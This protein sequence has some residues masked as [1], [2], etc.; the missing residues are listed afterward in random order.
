MQSSSIYNAVEKK[1]QPKF[2][3][4]LEKVSN[5]SVL[6]I[7]VIDVRPLLAAGRD[8]RGIHLIDVCIFY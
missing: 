2:S 6:Q 5:S 8:L 1:S 7:D 4:Q 3:K